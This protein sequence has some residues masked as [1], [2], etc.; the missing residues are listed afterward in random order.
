MLLKTNLTMKHK[1][2][3]NVLGK[4]LEV[5]SFFPMTGYKRTGSCEMS[6]GDDG[7][8]VVCAVVTDEF[9]QYSYS[10]GNDLITRRPGFWGLNEGDHWCLCR[11][12][13]LQAYRKD[14]KFAPPIIPEATHQ[15]LLKYISLEELKPFFI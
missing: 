5:C 11:D 10:Q 15:S 13:W 1:Q 7:R 14:P 12:R 3:L 8:H 9:L 2:Q 4:P 6:S